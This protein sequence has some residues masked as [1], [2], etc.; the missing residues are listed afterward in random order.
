MEIT[1]PVPSLIILI[2][3]SGSGKS[4][5]ATQHFAAT[6]IVSSDFCRAL[7]CD[8]ENDQ[9]VN[10]EAFELLHLLIAKRLS[11]HKLTVVDATN[12]KATSRQPLLE[13]AKSYDVPAIAI[14]FNFDLEFCLQQNAQR[15]HRVVPSEIIAEQFQ[16]LQSSLPQLSDEGFQNVHVLSS[17]IEIQVSVES[18]KSVES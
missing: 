10:Q 4:T 12:V 6:Q 15:I 1:I 2:G 5:F 14:V 3:V 13:F 8:D 7:I 9:G 18:M 11:L 16:E 17:V